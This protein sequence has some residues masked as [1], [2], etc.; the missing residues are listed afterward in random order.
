MWWENGT[1]W[2]G[3]IVMLLIMV[4]LWSLIVFGLVAIF[5]DG[6][7][8][9]AEGRRPDEAL[10]TLDQRFARGEIDVEE[11]HARQDILRGNELTTGPQRG[12]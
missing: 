10:Q 1:S 5:R 4:A 11:Y 8:G 6:R 2:G 9:P 12:A 3:W 7:S